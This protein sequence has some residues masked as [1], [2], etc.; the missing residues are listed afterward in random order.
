MPILILALAAA[1]VFVGLALILRLYI[2]S[3]R[4]MPMPRAGCGADILRL[5]AL[6]PA[7]PL[8]GFAILF[9]TAGL[10]PKRW[11]ARIGVGSVGISTI[12]ALI[13]MFSFLGSPKP[14]TEIVELDRRLRLHTGYRL[15]P[16]RVVRS[17]DAGRRLRQLSITSTLPSS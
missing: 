1:E 12:L 13:V 9:A 10:L 16:R 2:S 11:I 8:L 14:Y 15:L 5:L 6:I 3:G 17:D 4:S 7:L